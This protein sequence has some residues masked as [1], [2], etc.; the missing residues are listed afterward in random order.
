MLFVP[1]VSTRALQQALR[2]VS[3]CLLIPA[4]GSKLQTAVRPHKLS[5]LPPAHPPRLAKSPA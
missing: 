1:R 3:V 4:G 2:A 5:H